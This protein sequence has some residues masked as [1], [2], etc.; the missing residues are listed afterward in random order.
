MSIPETVIHAGRISAHIEADTSEY[1]PGVNVRFYFGTG[2]DY[3]D[4]LEGLSV[5]RGHA[6]LSLNLTADQCDHLAAALVAHAYHRRLH[7]AER[8]EPKPSYYKAPD[9]R[10][11]YRDTV[12]FGPSRADLMEQMKAAA[13]EQ[14]RHEEVT[15]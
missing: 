8:A 3:K 7:E 14:A 10:R 9:P 12:T 15:A 13:D 6:G 4:G 2:R 11:D 1:E 5:P